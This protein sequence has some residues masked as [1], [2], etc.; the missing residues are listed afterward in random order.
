MGGTSAHDEE[1]CP[2]TER[3]DKKH[4]RESS[5]FSSLFGYSISCATISEYMYLGF[6]LFHALSMRY[7]KVS[8]SSELWMSTL[9]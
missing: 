7:M 8:I 9:R 6:E 2:L 1:E 4:P 3:Q 5:R